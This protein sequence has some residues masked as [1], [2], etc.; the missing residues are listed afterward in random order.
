[1]IFNVFP[2]ILEVTM[3]GGILSYNLGYPY[4]IVVAS[5]ITA[6]TVFTVKVS[7]WRAGETMRRMMMDGDGLL[8]MM[9]MMMEY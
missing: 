2:T 7:D 3:V 1:M 9:M 8:M 4:A 5:T 6:Y